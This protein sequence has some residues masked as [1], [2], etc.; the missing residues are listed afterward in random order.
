MTIEYISYLGY[1]NTFHYHLRPSQGISVNITRT[2]SSWYYAGYSG[3]V[4]Y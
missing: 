2:G 3:L 1:L 4:F